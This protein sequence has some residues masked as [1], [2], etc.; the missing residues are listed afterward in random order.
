MSLTP[1]VEQAEMRAV[2]RRLLEDDR[3]SA[4]N[5]P[6]GSGIDR[7]LWRRLAHLGI[8][9]VVLPEEV[10]GMGL[11]MQ[12]AVVVAEELGRALAP[13]P[14]VMSSIHCA[15]LLRADSVSQQQILTGIASGELVVTAPVSMTQPPD[16]PV[17]AVEVAEHS[18]RLTGSLD[19]VPFGAD[20]DVILVAA[21]TRDGSK[22]FAVERGAGLQVTGQATIDETLPLSRVR[23]DATPATC[24]TGEDR[25][26][27]A[28]HRSCVAL[29]AQQ[30]GAA[31]WCLDTAVDYAKQRHQFGVPI[32]S[33]QAVQFK[34]A[35]MYLALE[36]SKSAVAYASWAADNGASDLESAVAITKAWCSD[37]FLHIAGETIQLLG[38]IGFTWEHDAHRYFKHAVATKPLFGSPDH[39]RRVLADRVG[40]GA[41]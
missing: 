15:T 27:L 30:V 6:P 40:L 1:S 17:D 2:V 36:E 23:L 9:G 37:S 39:H 19:A 4:G 8:A 41:L 13:V 3:R 14:F 31:G 29:S 12:E 35:D 24:L 5:R 22:L 10:G 7:D 20:A 21:E 32:G 16:G 34:C 28:I 11:G 18:W 33:F 26:P 25:S 38:G